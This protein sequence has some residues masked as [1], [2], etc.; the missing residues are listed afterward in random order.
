MLSLVIFLPLLGALLLA[1]MPESQTLT[2]KRMSLGFTLVT[3]LASL[4]VLFKF[5]TG[6]YHFQMIEWYQWIP[7]LGIA[8]KL[9]IDGISLWLVMLTTFLMVIATAFSY[10]VDKRVKQYMIFMLMLETAMLGVFLSLDLILF[11]S[12]FEASLIPMFF[13]INIWG[14]ER[15]TYAAFKFFAYTFAGSIFMLIGIIWMALLYKNGPGGDTMTFDIIT[16][17]H[18]VANGKL[19]VGAIQA[20]TVIFWFFAIAFMVKC[21]M[22]PF[23]TWLPDAHVEAPTAGSVI[24]AGVLLKM[25]TYGFL[26]FV[27]PFFPDVIRQQ[28]P[29]ILGLAVFGIIYGAIVA[30]AQTDVK[31]LVAYSSVAHMG[32]V[33]LGIFSLTHDGLMGGALQQLNHGIST[34]ALFLLIGLLYERRHTRKFADFG[35]LKAQMPV[36]STLFLIVMLSSVG[37]PGTNGFVGEFL[38]MYGA[39][40]AAYSGMFGLNL[41]FA[42]VAGFGVVLAAVYLLLMFMKVF[43]G[44][45]N[46]PENKR[47][48]DIKPWEQLL[49]GALVV[50]VFW[51]GLQPGYF[52]KKMEPS[53]NAVRMMALN[54][55]GM[56]P[57]YGDPTQEIDENGNFVKTSKRSVDALVP[58][59]TIKQIVPANYNFPAPEDP[60]GAA[61]TAELK[62]EESSK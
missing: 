53:I 57:S 51:V 32:F 56:R 5:Q 22:F 52:F 34:G 50:F 26:R 14:G 47:L 46:N 61:A 23:H 30:A 3:F 25:G 38:A 7:S 8:Y 24:L 44:P 39:F 13:L 12:F 19:W 49:V 59:T 27:L 42:V 17:Q 55:E 10:Y 4:G 28:V 16:L 31:K 33:M 2:I 43:Y 45:N 20:E 60:Q 62:T 18:Y 36:Y 29:I 11:Y 35:G 6:T 58:F 9:G 41:I 21:P 54:D 37:L 48:K 1:F 15:R 40:Q